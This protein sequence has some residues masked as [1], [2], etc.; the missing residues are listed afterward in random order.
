MKKA[1]VTLI[2]LLLT[3]ALAQLGELDGAWI[4]ADADT[5]GITRIEIS[6]DAA[7]ATIKAWG[8]CSP[9][10]CEWGEARATGYASSA[11]DDLSEAGS[12]L[13]AA[14][15][16]PHAE[17]MMT[18]VRSGERLEVGAF[19][20][21]TDGS[22]RTAYHRGETF[23]REVAVQVLPFAPS[24]FTRPEILEML[25]ESSASTLGSGSRR[26]LPDGSVQVNQPDGRKI[27]Y[28][29]GGRIVEHPDGTTT[30][31]TFIQIA[32]VPPAMTGQS[33]D[34]FNEMAEVLYKTIEF[35]VNNDE[36]SLSNLRSAE[37]GL[38]LPRLVS[39]R[40]RVVGRLLQ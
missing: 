2:A 20:R 28:S 39:S 34:W 18:I 33:E 21:F 13:I 4:N 3:H 1:L 10:D 14:Y 15:T 38:D 31:W 6:A 35:L 37:S 27:T 32:L 5:R 17:T 8:A 26:I 11:S 25:V 40:T 30:S 7:G 29:D 9:Q 23:R 22:G 19:T 12:A 16:F 36:A 24:V